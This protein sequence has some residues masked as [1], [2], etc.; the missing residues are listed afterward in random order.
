M[1]ISSSGSKPRDRIISAVIPRGVRSWPFLTG[2][3]VVLALLSACQKIW[4]TDIFWHLTEG[5]WALEHHTLQRIDHW[6]VSGGA[7]P[8]VAVYTLYHLV[9]TLLHSL[10]GF[11]G[12][13]ILNMLLF[14]A[15][16]IALAGA[17]PLRAR[18]VGAALC[19]AAA[20]FVIQGR[21][22]MRPESFTFLYLAV[23]IGLLEGVRRG[24]LPARRLLWLVPLMAVWAN[25]HSLF[26]VGL[27][28]IWM[29][30][31][32]RWIDARRPPWEWIRAAGL[33]TLAC[34]INPTPLQI[35]RL[36][37]DYFG[38]INARVSTYA[39]GFA[40]FL[41]SW[42]EP[43]APEVITIIVIVVLA[44]AGMAIGWWKR[45][46]REIPAAHLL[47]LAAFVYLGATAFRNLA[48]AGVVEGY[49]AASYAGALIPA[50]RRWAVWGASAAIVL[51]GTQYITGEVGAALHRTGRPGVGL[52][53]DF[54]PL[55]IAK[56][57]ASSNTPGDILPLDFGD[58]GPLIY[59]ANRDRTDPKT[60]I[61]RVYIDGRS[62]L[63]PQERY[64]EVFRIES[65]IIS[66]PDGAE[67]VTLPP[68]VRF[69]VVNFNDIEAL[70]SL[71]ASRR[72]RLYCLDRNHA[73]F[74]R[75]DD[76]ELCP[77]KI[78]WSEY[79]VPLSVDPPGALLGPA[80]PYRRTW[81]R[82]HPLDTQWRL[83]TVFAFL[84]RDDLA[85]RYL[86]SAEMLDSGPRA[87]REGMLAMIL[88]RL[89]ER[90]TARGDLRQFKPPA[91]ADPRL[92]RALFLLRRPGV[93]DPRTEE[94]RTHAIQKV[95][96]LNRAGARDL[97]AEE[98]DRFVA[99]LGGAYDPDLI[100]LRDEIR[101]G[102]TEAEGAE[103]FLASHPGIDPLGQA[104]ILSSAG[105]SRRALDLLAREPDRRALVRQGDI[106]LRMGDV[107]AARRL[108]MKASNGSNDE[109][110]LAI[111][112]WAEGDLKG[113][114][115]ILD[116]PNRHPDIVARE[117][118]LLPMFNAYIGIDDRPDATHARP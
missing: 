5:E 89:E 55:K 64:V 84:G 10:A 22:R 53:D 60:I 54:F 94:G 39:F 93:C 104:F 46:P 107:A 26:A 71:G 9:I 106:L 86:E 97:A 1:P 13:S 80:G 58:G 36:P 56:K 61:H 35:I 70:R 79:D 65:E 118:S 98:A 7:R 102:L 44:A 8:I 42:K 3:L 27:A 47:W 2:A 52:L 28:T 33:A 43:G 31:I 78:D 88:A 83:G 87:D 82:R 74:V 41:P 85:A 40:E 109:D 81:L 57:I 67:R 112:A 90:D 18:G 72:F 16:A 20:L 17:V 45:G 68:N 77:F 105:M 108:Y 100:S 96:L 24:D 48:L 63:H 113:A 30:A 110:R 73:C 14:A 38:Q 75:T 12:L 91:V 50:S 4:D 15:I 115:V 76:T 49:L 25:M 101:A 34:L 117:R 19:L 66:S 59:T 32:G 116:N 95:L 114:S 23:T 92:V 99:A 21:M 11:A 111:C 51:L 62:D 103:S 69:L 6:S 29:A 37:I